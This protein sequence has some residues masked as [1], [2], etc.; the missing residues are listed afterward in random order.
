[1]EKNTSKL[2]KVEADTLAI[3]GE[4]EKLEGRVEINR[5]SIHNLRNRTHGE[6]DK[7]KTNHNELEKIVLVNNNQIRVILEKQEKTETVV[8]N[9]TRAMHELQ[10]TV[11]DVTVVTRAALNSLKGFGWI[12]GIIATIIAVLIGLEKID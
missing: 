12:L 3:K 5:Q 2:V 8:E 4:M 10:G 7:I 6:F 11:H 9:N 1:M